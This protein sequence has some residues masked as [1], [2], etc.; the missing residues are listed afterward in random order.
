MK[1][2]LDFKQIFQE[3]NYRQPTC[4]KSKTDLNK[5]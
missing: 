4:E 3:S 1:S 2:A 5:L